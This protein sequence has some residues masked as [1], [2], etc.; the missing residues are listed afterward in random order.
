V[1]EEAETDFIGEDGEV[2][3]LKYLKGFEDFLS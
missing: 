1:F 2:M 3:V